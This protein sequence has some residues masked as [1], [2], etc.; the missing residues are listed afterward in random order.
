MR[1]LFLIFL[2]LPFTNLS[3]EINTDSTARASWVSHKYFW[4][5]EYGLA[6]DDGKSKLNEAMFNTYGV[7]ILDRTYFQAGFKGPISISGNSTKLNTYDGEIGFT[8]WPKEIR[9]SGD[10]INL[11]MSGFAF[12]YAMGKD[13]LYFL[14]W[15]DLST[16]IGFN[17]GMDF[18]RQGDRK[19]RNPYFAPKVNTELRFF[20]GRIALTARAEYLYDVTRFKWKPDPLTPG[21]DYAFKHQYFSFS[22]GLGY[23]IF[24]QTYPEEPEPKD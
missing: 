6:Y 10:S 19:F 3:Q 23:C 4:S 12:N 18:F 15:V 16:K 21:D 1:S 7:N 2:F 5:A 9:N 13:F 14:D 17:W 20:I 24:P 11:S 22:F 8:F